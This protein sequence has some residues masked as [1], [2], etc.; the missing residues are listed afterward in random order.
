MAQ[1]PH[2]PPNRGGPP[3]RGGG[4]TGPPALHPHPEGEETKQLSVK[5]PAGGPLS[6]PAVN[7][8]PQGGGQKAP[9]RPQLSINSP[10]GGGCPQSPSEHP[11]VKHQT[12][13]GSQAPPLSVKTPQGGPKPTLEP[14][15]YQHTTPGG[16]PRDPHCPA[17]A[18]GWREG[19]LK[20]LSTPPTPSSQP[21]PPG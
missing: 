1:A 20:P 7:Q 14:P 3:K 21:P 12:W 4:H 11:A 6:P 9:Q 13:G 15:S 8:Q 5:S 19:L 2:K 18:P 17:P 16:G 10:R